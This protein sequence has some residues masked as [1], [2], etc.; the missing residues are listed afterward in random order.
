MAALAARR[1]TWVAA[2]A[3]W[4]QDTL[5][6]PRCGRECRRDGE[7]WGCACGLRR[8]RPD[9]WLEDGDLVS[10]AGGCSLHLGLPGE[11]NRANAAMAVAAA[12]RHGVA[13]GGR[14]GR[15]ARH[16]LGGR[17]ATTSSAPPPT[18]ARLILAKNPASWAEALRTVAS[19]PAPLV[20]AF[21]SEG[22]DGRDPSWLY[23][24]PFA[25]LAGRPV[26]VTGRRSTDM[27]VRLEMD[28]LDRRGGGPDAAAGAWRCCRPARS[29]VVANYTA[30]QEARRVLRHDAR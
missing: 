21:N 6:C 8:P 15:D 20:L 29:T 30:F 5:V 7:D 10:D 26:V 12:A 22:V 13:P 17:P 2:G 18:G 28:G 3:R 19:T 27:L 1:Q 16:Q 9:W 25:D 14:R 23:D 24:V 4:S 11:V